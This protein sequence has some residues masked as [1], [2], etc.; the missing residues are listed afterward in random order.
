MSTEVFGSCWEYS[1]ELYCSLSSE[2][3]LLPA[4]KLKSCNE[5]QN[6]SNADYRSGRGR[7]QWKPNYLKRTK[8]SMIKYSN[9]IL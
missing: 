2:S 6:I 4:R 9:K 1:D 7:W 8:L 3:Q 5:L